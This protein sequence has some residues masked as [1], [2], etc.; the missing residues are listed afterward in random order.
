M[1]V[2]QLFNS[3]DEFAN[4]ED[5]FFYDCVEYKE[6]TNSSE[7]GAYPIVRGLEEVGTL[8]MA[9][10]LSTGYR[11]LLL[12]HSWPAMAEITLQK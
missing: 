7:D 8:V 1:L 9:G 5:H 10:L 2:L 11:S 12:N 4:G 3:R 6:S